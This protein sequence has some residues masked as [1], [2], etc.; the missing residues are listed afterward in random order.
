[1][2]TETKLLKYYRNG[3]ISKEQYINLVNQH[4]KNIQT[5]KN[6]ETKTEPK[7]HPLLQYHQFQQYQLNIANKITKQQKHNYKQSKLQSKQSKLTP[8]ISVDKKKE[9]EDAKIK[10]ETQKIR[11]KYLLNVLKDDKLVKIEQGKYIEPLLEMSFEDRLNMLRQAFV[12]KEFNSEHN[13][14]DKVYLLD[15][16]I[17]KK[18]LDRTR[19]GENMF[20]NEVK[21]LKLLL[22]YNHFPK[23]I[24]YDS[25]NLA[26]YMSYC[27][28]LINVKNL[29]KNWKE[30]LDKIGK[31]LNEA[32][33]NSNDMILRNTCVLDGRINIIDFGMPAMFKKDIGASVKHLYNRIMTLEVRKRR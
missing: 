1:M 6:S 31:Y 2:N 32:D 21:A 19:L 10:S 3:V 16:F 7:Y 11:K 28:D 12:L 18:Q 8:N 22:P 26:I 25:Y 30:Q 24:S 13:Y 33:V 27:G 29:P 4:N 15:G 14:S 20:W 9:L 5:K 23:L 17:V